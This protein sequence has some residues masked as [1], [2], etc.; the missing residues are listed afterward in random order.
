MKTLIRAVTLVVLLAGVGG[1]AQA[2]R[3]W[4]D[5]G[6]GRR[7][8]IRGHIVVGPRFQY[9]YARPYVVRPHLYRY[10]YRRPVVIAPRV[11]LRRPI[12]RHRSYGHYR[13]F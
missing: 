8:W 2:Q 13:W 4:V 6:V 12:I 1:V 5:I 3:G 9:R 7:P 10:N 11:Y